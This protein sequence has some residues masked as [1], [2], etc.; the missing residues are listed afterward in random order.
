M[1]RAIS[2]PKSAPWRRAT[3]TAS[4]SV[5]RRARCGWLA[6]WTASPLTC[7][8]TRRQ[9]KSSRWSSVSGTSSCC[10]TRRIPVTAR[11]PICR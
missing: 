11:P 2:S 6:S 4:S 9:L 8:M 10:S 1:S 7:S 5:P 3:S